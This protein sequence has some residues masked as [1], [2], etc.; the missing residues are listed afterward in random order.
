V[1]A[2]HIKFSALK[3]LTL[4]GVTGEVGDEVIKFTSCGGRQFN[5]FHSQEC[6]E[7]VR[8]EDICGDLQDLIGSPIVQAEESSN[9]SGPYA[10]SESYTWTF[11]RIATAK[12]LVVIRW[13]GESNGYYSEGVDF[14]EI[15]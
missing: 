6:C 11:Y 9:E 10:G 8:V 12:G 2:L 1:R 3:G 4:T 13:L 5:L 15:I 7:R 14:V